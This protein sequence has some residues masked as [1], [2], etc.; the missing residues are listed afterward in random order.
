[1]LR[2][3]QDRE[4]NNIQRNVE[5]LL[6]ETRKKLNREKS[7][8][9][10]I[11][12]RQRYNKHIIVS[13]DRH[14]TYQPSI[15]EAEERLERETINKQLRLA[16]E[17]RVYEASLTTRDRIT[18]T[19]ESAMTNTKT[20]LIQ[21]LNKRQEKIITPLLSTHN[22]LTLTLKDSIPQSSLSLLKEKG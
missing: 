14:V 9:H 3:L 7:P 18:H 20:I 21:N 2:I 12:I 17:K 10:E 5:W 1:M 16:H 11:L 19:M 8:Y 6:R 13:K 15:E 22:R 4:K